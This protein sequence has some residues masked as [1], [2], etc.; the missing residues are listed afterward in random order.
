[1]EARA[2]Y[3]SPPGPR[4]LSPHVA[5]WLRE[6][7]FQ[8]WEQ[9]TPTPSLSLVTGTWTG[10][11]GEQF[12]F[13]YAHHHHPAAGPVSWAACSMGVRPAGAREPQVC[14]A[15]TQVRRLKEVRLLVL[16]NDQ[17]DAA[18]QRLA[19]ARA[20]LTKSISPAA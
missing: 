12:S 7:G 14:F 4:D 18:R 10:L 9:P 20:T 15:P 5:R 6:L 19:A 11:T 16:G 17:F 2:P 8:V 3:G 13:Q 1:M